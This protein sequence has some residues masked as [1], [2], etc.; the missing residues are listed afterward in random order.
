M[1]C[2]VGVIPDVPWEKYFFPKSQLPAWIYTRSVIK[3]FTWI[4]FLI[5]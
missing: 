4:E 3:Y 2:G 5:L 1:T